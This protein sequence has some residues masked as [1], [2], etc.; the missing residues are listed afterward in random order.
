MFAR[1]IK[2]D[3]STGFKWLDIPPAEPMTLE[4]DTIFKSKFSNYYQTFINSFL[5]FVRM[6]QCSGDIKMLT[7]I[8][9]EKPT[10]KIATNNNPLFG[11]Y[12][13]DRAEEMLDNA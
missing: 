13:G 6:P 12:D 1:A 8:V 5:T 2:R 4:Q 11:L 3:I 9:V 7:R 10:G